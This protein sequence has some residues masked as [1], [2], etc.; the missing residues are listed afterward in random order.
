MY[1]GKPDAGWRANPNL[2]R[3]DGWF[4]SWVMG[5]CGKSGKWFKLKTS[6]HAAK[7]ES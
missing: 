7:Q 5:T 1:D 3:E 4:W 6:N 2:L